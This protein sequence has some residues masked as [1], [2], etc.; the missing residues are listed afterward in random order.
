MVQ[1]NGIALWPG[2]RLSADLASTSWKVMP[3]NS[4]VRTLRTRLFSRARP[5]SAPVCSVL[6]SC[7]LHLMQIFEHTFEH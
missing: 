3:A 1:P 2:T 5:G 6:S 4:G 7:A